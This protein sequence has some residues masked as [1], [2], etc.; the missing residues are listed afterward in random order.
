MKPESAFLAH[1]LRALALTITLITLVTL[2]TVGYTAYANVSDTLNLLG[3][4]SPTSAI[5]TKTVLLGSTT[6]IYLNMTLTNS[7]FYPVG[8]SLTCIPP[9]GSTIT[10]NSPSIIVY[11]AQSKTLHFVMTIENSF[12][13]LAGD[14][15]VDGT[16]EVSLSPFA[17]INLAVDL[18][19]LIN[20]GN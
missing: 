13:G 4:N 12:Q 11:P 19:S 7:G 15:H 20:R 5:T 18:G 3:G 17:S 6:T 1:S 14:L 2:S 16:L 9:N 10:C 8:L